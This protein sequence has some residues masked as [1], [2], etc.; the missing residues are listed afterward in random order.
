[1]GV[2]VVS[3]ETPGAKG[4]IEH[5]KTG[6]LSPVGNVE[7]LSE[8][9]LRVLQNEELRDTLIQNA[10]AKSRDYSWESVAKKHIDLYDSLLRENS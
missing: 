5:E 2:P 9:I 6:M 7:K 1:M 8:N 4:L 3:T 10:L